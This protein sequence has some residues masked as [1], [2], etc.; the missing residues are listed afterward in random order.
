[1]F[2]FIFIFMK[3]GYAAC[4]FL[5]SK[6][7]IKEV[8]VLYERKRKMILPN[9]IIVNRIE[10]ISFGRF[11]KSRCSVKTSNRRNWTWNTFQSNEIATHTTEEIHHLRRFFIVTLKA[12]NVINQIGIR[13]RGSKLSQN[14]DL[15]H[16]CAFLGNLTA[17][18][19]MYVHKL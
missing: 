19:A 1:M 17:A 8:S 13:H 14:D 7:N 16:L 4:L 3:K 2:C 10:D 12:N 11:D 6:I 5:T 18:Y 9:T 15:P